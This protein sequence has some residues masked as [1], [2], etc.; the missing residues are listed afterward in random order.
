M[1]WGGERAQ[2]ADEAARE[3]ICLT[4]QRGLSLATSQG[5]TMWR[6]GRSQ[7]T[8]IESLTSRSCLVASITVWCDA[9]LWTQKK[10]WWTSLQ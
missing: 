6:G 5:A 9:H 10:R 7:G 8:T 2:R 1:D 3:L 4:T